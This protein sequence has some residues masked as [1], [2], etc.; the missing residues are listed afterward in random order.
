[1]NLVINFSCVRPAVKSDANFLS[2][3]FTNPHI[4]KLSELLQVPLLLNYGS[5]S[6]YISEFVG[7]L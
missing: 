1:M 5:L 3:S 7:T 2:E 4:Q 6:I